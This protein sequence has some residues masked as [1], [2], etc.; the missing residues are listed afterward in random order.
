MIINYPHSALQYAPKLPSRKTN[1]W[2]HYLKT[3]KKIMLFFAIIVNIIAGCSYSPSFNSA[4]PYSPRITKSVAMPNLY[5]ESADYY[6]H[7]AD[8]SSG[9]ERDSFLLKASGR[10]IQNSNYEQAQSLLTE[11]DHQSLPQSLLQEKILLESRLQ[12]KKQQATS[13]LH[14]LATL[15]NSD[16]LAPVQKIYYYQLL[17]QAYA[18]TGNTINS[19]QA[20]IKLNDVLTDPN[21]K[22]ENEQQI[23][24]NLLSLD[25]AALHTLSLEDSEP[26]MRGWAQL[27][28][29]NKQTSTPTTST[30]TATKRW[31]EQYPNHPGQQFAVTTNNSSGNLKPLVQTN[32]TN[33]NL[34]HAYK[35]ALLLPTQGR[36]ASAGQAVQEGFMATYNQASTDQRQQI[37]IATYDTS[38]GSILSMYQRALQDGANFIVGPLV[39][40]QVQQLANESLAVPT[41]ALNYTHL[42]RTTSNLYEFGL[43]PTLEASLVANKAFEDGQRRIIII[44]PQGAWGNEVTAAFLQQWQQLGGTVVD[45]LSY[46]PKQDFSQAIKQLLQFSETKAHSRQTKKQARHT[47]K[48]LNVHRRKD[49]DSI[50]L[51]ATPTL[52]RQIRPLLKFYY[53]GEVPVYATSMIYTGK[54]SPQ[55]DRDLD[56]IIFCDSPWV[57][58]Q[59][60][61][62]S[63]DA[64]LYALGID[65]YHIATQLEQMRNSSRTSITTP[66]GNLVLQQNY[67]QRALSWAQ[68]RNGVPQ[69]LEAARIR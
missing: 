46:T 53:A 63:Q 3:N 26:E 47:H 31:Q 22:L 12:L 10:L 41:L 58:T 52:G 20:R 57:L 30:I 51:L 21:A 25:Q 8:E 36:Y 6:L 15:P 9:T 35:I 28:M 39:K 7:R 2:Q 34:D 18:N 16:D 69:L 59:S 66:T 13:A 50:L 54:L 32:F 40:N 17:A 5:P 48:N 49:M 65:A 38:H 37:T 24:N 56:G 64:R 43:S 60:K 44:R 29:I 68:F 45:E 23:W 55:D 67:V 27:A 14:T 4:T 1:I 33:T 19:T 11:V 62:L 61:S 42:N